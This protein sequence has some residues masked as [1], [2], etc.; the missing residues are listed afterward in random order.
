MGRKLYILVVLLFAGS[1]ARGVE[2]SRTLKTFDFKERRLGNQGDLPI[3]WTK[4]TGPGLPHYVNGK[5]ANDRHRSGDYSFRFD[6]NGGGLIYRYEPGQIPV[7]H[8]AH[9]R[10][11]VW[12]QTNH[13]ICVSWQCFH[14]STPI[15]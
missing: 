11:E 13:H 7:Q 3:G 1:L 12:T 4:V 2:V 10:V 15:P 8:G 14:H 6:L 9:Y 5:L